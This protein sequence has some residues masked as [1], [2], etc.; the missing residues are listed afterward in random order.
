MGI[1]VSLGEVPRW[2]V[3]IRVAILGHHMPRAYAE[4]RLANGGPP[5]VAPRAGHMWITGTGKLA[6]F[7][8]MSGLIPLLAAE[9]P[10]IARRS[11][12]THWCYSVRRPHTA[13]AVKEQ[14]DVWLPGER[15][16]A[17]GC[18]TDG[19]RRDD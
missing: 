5:L 16:F 19:G 12:I 7:S 2:R 18:A 10:R 1:E 8:S 14:L 3:T 13:A 6:R 11:K 15:Y 4:H 9:L 17:S